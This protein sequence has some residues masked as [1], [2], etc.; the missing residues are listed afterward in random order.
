[1]PLL[2]ADVL[3]TAQGLL[4]RN[5]L[6]LHT[7]LAD[8]LPQV[9]ADPG[10]VRQ[11]LLNLLS[12]AIKFTQQGSITVSAYCVSDRAGRHFCAAEDMQPIPQSLE[13]DAPLPPYVA[14]SVRDTGIGIP[15]EQQ[16]RI[17]DE[18]YQVHGHPH[19]SQGTGLGLS[20]VRRM[21]EAQG[22]SIRVESVPRA[23]S[24]FTFTLPVQGYHAHQLALVEAQAE[25]EADP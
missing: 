10:R 19:R 3:S 13:P 9:Y 18:F 20:I 7:A 22:G 8:M 21:V 17:F 14:V 24:T 23:G 4:P 2:I 15:P 16:Q 1:L 5:Q 6:V 25:A 12:N 11:V